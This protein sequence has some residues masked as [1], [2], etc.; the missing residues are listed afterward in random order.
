MILEK[1]VVENFRQF[2]GRQ[3]IVFSDI[4]DRNVTLIHAENG[5]GKTALL[6]ALLWGFYGH[7][8]LTADLPKKET[9]IHEG[10][11]ARAR[12]GAAT[13]ARV[14]IWFNHDG[15]KF[16]LTRELPLEQQ[17][18][19]ARKTDLTLE[20][21]QDGM[22]LPE[23]YAQARIQAIMPSGISEFLFFNGE[24]I[25]HLAMEENAG[26]VTEAIRQMLGLTLLQTAIEDLRHQSVLGRLRNELR[27]R[28]SEEKQAK[29][30]EQADVDNQ[31]AELAKK[32]EL[33]QKNLMATDAE[34]AM[35]D[36]KLE[37]NREAHLKQ[38]RRRDLLKE[39]G[40][41]DQKMAEKDKRL[42]QIL[43]EDSY[44]LFTDDLVKRG[45]EI[46]AKLRQ[47]GKIPARVLNTFLKE[48]LEN[49]RCICQRQLD[50]GS[51]E[52]KAVEELMTFAGDQKFNEAVGAL[53]NAIGRIEE[54]TQRTRDSM[55]EVNQERLRLK[56][57]LVRIKEEL[58]AIHQHLG[59]R[60]DEEVGKLEETREKLLLTQRELVAEQARIDQKLEEKTKDR[61]K[62][63]DEIKDIE[64]NEV[65][66][67]RAQRRL[68]AVEEAGSLLQKILDI[69]TEELRPVL[70]H[71]IDEH[72]R[73]IMDRA[74]WAELTN[75]FRLT[76]KKKVQLEDMDTR[77]PLE[78]DV[79]LS[80]GQRQITSLVFIASLVALARR[81][82]EIPTIV[83]G[84]TGS[85]C[86]MV[87]DSPFGQLST[88]FRAGVAKWI[89]S[90]A[91]QVIIL[92]SHTQY[93]GAVED[94]LKKSRRVGKRYYL[95]YHG[96]EL[97][98]D[99]ERELKIGKQ[100][101]EVYFE[102]KEEFTEVRELEG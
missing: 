94:E 46:V 39:Q 5:F 3:E 11:A 57:D 58:A 69:E 37:L 26:Q 34:L 47:E 74:Y 44:V 42:A 12:D 100:P 21:Y 1:L 17:K 76:I 89:P 73:K 70:N 68:D 95:A 22:L 63:R 40:E 64:D 83:K 41:L 79:A 84:L 10:V 90:L 91:P 71:E 67:Q 102:S 98:K 9:V 19:D 49:H 82:S 97:P 7:D 18:L 99:A 24:R 78:I 48:L 96:P 27:E 87:M 54:A 38:M 59:G 80:Q 55:D 101:I 50:D 62:L 92:V 66:A 15:E 13:A 31:I 35:V 36:T 85:E 61:E 8:G 53:D 77:K 2:R 23:R 14:V 20:R 72:F 88:R 60:A 86:P 16:C 28:T 45:R 30:D 52:R 25:D 65:D 75:D 33:A 6:N 29:I 81:R 56:D 4:K 32:K 51:A 43:A 93:N